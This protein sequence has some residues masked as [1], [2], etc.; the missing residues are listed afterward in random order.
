MLRFEKRQKEKKHH[1]TAEFVIVV[2]DASINKLCLHLWVLK[3]MHRQSFWVLAKLAWK[4]PLKTRQ[5]K[6]C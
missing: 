6:A 4:D 5:I 3:L 2:T 1:T